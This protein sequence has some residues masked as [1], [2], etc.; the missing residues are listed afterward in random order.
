MENVKIDGCI[1]YTFKL[2]FEALNFWLI[3]NL[4]TRH[5]FCEFL[6]IYKSPIVDITFKKF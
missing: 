1:V 6:E 3:M 2:Q 4:K 5:M